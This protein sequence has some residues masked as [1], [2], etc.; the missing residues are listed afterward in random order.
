MCLIVFAYKKHPKFPLILLANRDEFYDRPTK[1]AHFWE[2]F[3]E[4]Y[5]GRDEVF[6][7]TWLGITKNGRFSALTNFRQ[8]AQNKGEI[9][10]GN[11]VSDFLKTNE[12]VSEYLENVRKT[13]ENYSGFNLLTGIFTDEFCELGYL[14]NRGDGEIKLL[15]AGI[16][17]LSNH[18]LD[19]NWKKV[20]RTK[21]GLTEII[22]N[23]F[24]DEDLFNLLQDKTLAEDKDLPNTGIGIERERILSPVFIET[25]V[26]GTRSSAIVLFEKDLSLKECVYR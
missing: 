24:S 8:A 10:R 14:S 1:S 25:P 22:S 7:G 13:S 4:I 5:A 15:D 18:L 11:L 3:P 6:G 26:Y 19:T 16:Y 9:S 12:S 21:S 2:D 17:G 20:E 23:N